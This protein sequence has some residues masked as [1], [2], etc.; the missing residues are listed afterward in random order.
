MFTV[1]DMPRQIDASLVDLLEKAETATI[2]HVLYRGFV[3]RA[4]TPLLPGRRVAGTAVTMPTPHFS[5][6]PPN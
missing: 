3:D 1:N 4:L 5:I 2:G 6:T